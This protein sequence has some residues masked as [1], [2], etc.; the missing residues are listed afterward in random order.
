[1]LRERCGL[2]AIMA[3]GV[4]QLTNDGQFLDSQLTARAMCQRGKSGLSLN[5]Q[6]PLAS[7]QN[8]TLFAFSLV[9]SPKNQKGILC[10]LHCHW[11]RSSLKC[12]Q[13]VSFRSGCLIEPCSGSFHCQFRCQSNAQWF[14]STLSIPFWLVGSLQN[15]AARVTGQPGNYVKLRDKLQRKLCLEACV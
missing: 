3:R 2:V 7:S 4:L 11:A 14:S 5:E 15:V 9:V 8:E 6:P 10:F 12:A 1:M 13:N